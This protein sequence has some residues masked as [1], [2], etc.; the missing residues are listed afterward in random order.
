M[1]FFATSAERGLRLDV[2]LERHLAGMSRS[3]IQSLIRS[4]HI[5][6]RDRPVKAHTKVSEGLEACV[7]IPAPAPARLTGEDI[8]L[9]ILYEDADLIV[10][11]KPVGM[12]VHPAAG[13]STGTLVHA[14]LNHCGDLG[15]VGGETRPGIVHRLDRDTSGAMVAAKNDLA[16]NELA[17]QF[18][19][20]RVHKEY[21]ALVRGVPAPA[22]GT[23]ETLIGRSRHDRKKMSARPSSGRTAITHYR[24]VKVFA[25]VSLLRVRIET[26]RT[27][28]IRVHMAHIGHPV[29]GDPQYGGRRGASPVW[30]CRQML[31]AEHLS[32]LH[33]RTG[34][35]MD[36]HA[37]LPGDMEE[38]L[39][40]LSSLLP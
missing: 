23:I 21:L 15:G 7:E 32:F 1:H 13:H 17:K 19:K 6:V 2:W 35:A 37:P 3:R 10:V 4:G 28:Q 14:L 20:G 40:R 27:H 31:H 34:Q 16:M 18:K 22:A 8:P 26:G 38:M 33:P 5:T 9:N 25:G 12:V 36:F 39:S 24:L 29:I 11:N 30:A